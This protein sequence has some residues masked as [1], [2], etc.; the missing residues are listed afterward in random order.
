LVYEKKSITASVAL[1][2]CQ[3]KKSMTDPQKEHPSAY[4]VQD[5]S[6]LE[7]MARLEI[8]DKMLN[9][10]MGGVLPELADHSSL[11]RV[12][13]VGCGTGGW[14]METARTYPTIE[15]LIGIDISSTMI[16][17][18]RAQAKAQ[19]LDERVE[20]QTMDALRVLEFP[21]AFFDLV[22]QRLGLSWLRT[23]EW[24][25]ILLEY[26]RVVRPSGIV[27]ITEGHVTNESNSPA[28]T[29]LCQISLEVCFRSG[30][31]FTESSDGVV[32][33]LVHLMTLHGLEDVKS[34]LYTLV[35]R[36]GTESCQYFYEDM[37]HAFRVAVPFFQKWTRLPNDYEEIYQ[38]ALHEMQ[39][40]NFEATMT[41]V[42]AWG[43]RSAGGNI[44]RMRGL[45]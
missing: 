21:N 4:F 15:K 5:R 1:S 41:L 17:Y 3:E 26:Q 37:L 28:L 20:F 44:P 2:H 45:R 39:Q 32:S 18:A 31:L 30:R 22:N 8:Q 42:T 6:N 24:K 25:K 40:P 13:D 34:H 14:L 9:T 43:I 16:T 38:Q 29:K 7:E 19:A 36:A 12:L 35:Y 23:W 33:E 27:R 11:R 10:M